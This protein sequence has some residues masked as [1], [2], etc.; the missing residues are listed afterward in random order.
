MTF[1]RKEGKLVFQGKKK[2]T[3]ILVISALR[4]ERMVEKRCESF[5]ATIIV[6]GTDQEVLLSEIPLVQEF[7]DVFQKLAG[8]PPSRDEP[9]T[10]ELEPG[11][12]HISKAPYG[13]APT[14][15]AELKK[16]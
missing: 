9:F 13:M 7:E 15:M 11:T 8:L 14:E 5:I 1:T 10:I 2:E 3:G 6:T 16:P 12:A 4:A